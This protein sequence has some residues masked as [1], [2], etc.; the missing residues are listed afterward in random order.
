MRTHRRLCVTVSTISLLVVFLSPLWPGLAASQANVAA[1]G[2]GDVVNVKDYGAKGDG[3]TDDTAAI[4][5]AITAAKAYAATQT[6]A[7][8]IWPRGA[9]NV[10]SLNYVGASRVANIALGAVNIYGTSVGGT[11]II[12]YDGGLTVPTRTPRWQG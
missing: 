3:R 9:Y 6:E 10:T 8:I 2:Q 1:P 7:A 4:Q 12:S 11:S 5:A